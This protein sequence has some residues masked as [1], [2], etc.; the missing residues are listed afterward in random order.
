MAL[1]ALIPPRPGSFHLTITALPTSA[2]AL[3]R[4]Q[5]LVKRAEFRTFPPEAQRLVREWIAAATCEQ[6]GEKGAA[7]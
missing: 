1:P 2:D 6:H 4:A 7:A 5:A 3:A